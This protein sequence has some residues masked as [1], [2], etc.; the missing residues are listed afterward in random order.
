MMPPVRVAMARPVSKPTTT[1][2]CQDGKYRPRHHHDRERG[3]R[4]RRE[5]RHIDGREEQAPVEIARHQAERDGGETG[6]AADRKPSE[7]QERGHAGK[8]D[9]ERHDMSDRDPVGKI[10]R[11]DIGREH[12]K[13]RPVVPQRKFDGL[14]VGAVLEAARVPGERL[15]AVVVGVEL[16]DGQPVVGRRCKSYHDHGTQQGRRRDDFRVDHETRHPF[17]PPGDRAVKHRQFCS[18][19]CCTT[20]VRPADWCHRGGTRSAITEVAITRRGHCTPAHD[21]AHACIVET[22]S[23]RPIRATCPFWPPRGAMKYATNGEL[24]S[25]A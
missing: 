20:N 2:A 1:V 18:L 5:K 19:D 24:K 17:P 9:Q 12:V 7:R 22:R 8:P 10:K 14:E 21:H 15:G 4:H 3:P 6:P 11:L 25:H 16:V 23:R 13:P